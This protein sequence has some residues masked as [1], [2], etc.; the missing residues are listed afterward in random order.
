MKTA[1]KWTWVI[2]A[3]VTAVL[4]FF[5]GFFLQG[6]IRALVDYEAEM[7][8][9]RAEMA[10]CAAI[11]GCMYCISP[12]LEPLAQKGRI[13]VTVASILFV[14]LIVFIVLFLVGISRNSK[15]NEKSS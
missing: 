14:G 13:E 11:P 9:V 2:L 8:Q 12:N 10:E 6:G 15:K 3:S 4:S 5:I 7:E 1:N